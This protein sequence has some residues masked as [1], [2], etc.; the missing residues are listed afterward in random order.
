MP[1]YV[2]ILQMWHYKT[3]G[4]VSSPG[5]AGHPSSVFFREVDLNNSISFPRTLTDLTQARKLSPSSCPA[6]L[7]LGSGKDTNI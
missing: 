2:D 6:T 7:W 5:G 3:L 1:W 4:I